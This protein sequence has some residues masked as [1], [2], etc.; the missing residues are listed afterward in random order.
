MQFAFLIEA[1]QHLAEDFGLNVW[2]Y[3][4]EGCE[5]IVESS[6]VGVF[7]P[8]MHSI[9]CAHSIASKQSFARCSFHVQALRI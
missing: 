2:E 9:Y 5:E 8:R 6:D 1:S 7:N 3:G 4:S